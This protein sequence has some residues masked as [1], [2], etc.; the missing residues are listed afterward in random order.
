M[1]QNVETQ[2]F[3]AWTDR[4]HLE[5]L[6][7]VIPI[8]CLKVKLIEFTTISCRPRLFA[9]FC[10]RDS[11]H[12]SGVFGYSRFGCSSPFLWRRSAAGIMFCVHIAFRCQQE[13]SWFGGY[14][15]NPTHLSLRRWSFTHWFSAV[16]L[17]S[18]SKFHAN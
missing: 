18:S 16:C 1:F 8:S 10:A 12:Q 3:F 14:F 6:K 9:G 5:T 13:R 4:E 7:I 11:T 17:F 2:V 15:K